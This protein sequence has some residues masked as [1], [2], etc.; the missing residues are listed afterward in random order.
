MEGFWSD[1][2]NMKIDLNGKE[3]E[4]GNAI[5]NGGNAGLCKNVTI[6][7]KKRQVDEPEKY[8]DYKLFAKDATGAEISQGFY[9]FT[10][11]PQKDE[12]Q[13]EKRATQEVSRV[14]HIA[15]AVLGSDYEFPEIGT[16]K[17]AYDVLFTL[18]N[19]NAGDKKFN[20]FVTYGTITRPSKYLGIRY[21]DFVESAE[22]AS[23]LI[24]KRGDSMERIVADSPVDS[25]SQVP[26]APKVEKWG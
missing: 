7:V 14:L 23:R 12:A 10:P 5:F 22:G 26:N 19:D 3:F 11:N 20:V 17:E 4:G 18:V 2:L 1:R 25:G 15:R 9:Y 6:E 16:V 24:T 8:P 13:N 21:F